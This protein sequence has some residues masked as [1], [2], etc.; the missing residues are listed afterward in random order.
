MRS[1]QLA[2]YTFWIN[3]KQSNSKLLSGDI[4]RHDLPSCFT[5]SVQTLNEYILKIWLKGKMQS[6]ILSSNT[7][8]WLTCC[9]T[10]HKANMSF[11]TCETR[12]TWQSFSLLSKYFKG[13]KVVSHAS[14]NIS[15]SL[16]MFTLACGPKVKSPN[17]EREAT[18]CIQI[19]TSCANAT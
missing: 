6:R 17:K 11:A 2:S 13:N 10:W 5:P 9:T 1:H 14:I 4:W 15:A 7:N 3:V 18:Y 8:L 12:I 19:T 16:E